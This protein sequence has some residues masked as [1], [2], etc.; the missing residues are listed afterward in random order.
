MPTL[1]G[2]QTAQRTLGVRSRDRIRVPLDELPHTA[3]ASQRARHPKI[4]S[5]DLLSFPGSSSRIVASSASITSLPAQRSGLWPRGTGMFWRGE[6][7]RRTKAARSTNG[8]R[9]RSDSAA[10][11][12]KSR[13]LLRRRRRGRTDSAAP[14]RRSR[15]DPSRVANRRRPHATS[16]ACARRADPFARQ[17]CRRP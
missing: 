13:S 2:T 17:C 12:R 3:F 15:A 6:R 1:L 11:G 4:E 5:G 8:R 14:F 10:G 9:R 7:D 16:R